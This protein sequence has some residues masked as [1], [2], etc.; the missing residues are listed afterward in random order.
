M[1]IPDFIV[2]LREMVGNHPLFL[3]GVSVV[4]RD[5]AGRILL[6]RPHGST[7]WTLVTGILE[8]GEQPAVAA[9]REVAEET[10]VTAR[11]TDL[12]GVWTM[13]PTTYSNGHRAQYLDLTFR[14]EQVAGQARVAD[15]ECE[16]VGW[17]A[18]SALPPLHPDSMVRLERSLQFDGRAWFETA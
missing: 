2:E 3:S 6:V 9:V 13:P 12:V 18:L 4:V 17:F 14:A 16:E 5:A 7:V 11:V 10:G 8:P 1:P 15:D